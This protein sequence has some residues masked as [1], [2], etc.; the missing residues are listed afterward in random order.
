MITLNALQASNYSNDT[1]S[2]GFGLVCPHFCSLLALRFSF[3][4]FSTDN[5][6]LQDLLAITHCYF[7]LMVVSRLVE[8]KEEYSLMFWLILNLRYCEPGSCWY[9]LHEWS[10]PPPSCTT[11]RSTYSC[12]LPPRS[13]TFFAPVPFLSC[14]GIPQYPNLAVFIALALAH[15]SFCSVVKI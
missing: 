7:Y 2:L 10:C 1:L 13:R 6:F 12:S 4:L 11:G 9:G 14:D 3:S 5:L 15:C 8:N